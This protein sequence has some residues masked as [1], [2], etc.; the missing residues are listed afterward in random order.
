MFS[1]KLENLIKAALQ[2]GVLTE[3]EKNAIIKRAQAEG[4]DIDEVDI[5][6]QSLQ[7]KRQAELQEKAQ[8]TADE[9]LKARK[10]A[11]EAKTKADQEEEKERATILR[12]CPKCGTLI[13]NLTNVCPECGFIIDK[14]ETDKDVT[15]IIKLL[16]ECIDLVD[17]NDHDCYF[18]IP[19]F[20][21]KNYKN[22][23]KEEY[24]KS[25]NLYDFK[26]NINN[27]TI[28]VVNNYRGIITEASLYKDND[29]IHSLLNELRLKEKTILLND[30]N[31]YIK[32][33]KKLFNPSD[34][35]YADERLYDMWLEGLEKRF[36]Y[37]EDNYSDLC[38]D[39]IVRI[40]KNIQEIEKKHEELLSNSK[41]IKAVKIQSGD[42]TPIHERI[43]EK[44]RDFL[45]WIS[46]KI[47]SFE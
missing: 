21:E 24:E 43:F 14:T 35:D 47:K 6:I 36:H 42:Y 11:Q 1:E 31:K 7:Q 45:S 19:D 32:F 15:K 20:W 33:T 16:Q 17:L 23:P 8:K 29:I 25:P 34:K 28:R 22:I 12:K 5:Y 46:D 4:E 30:T 27:N 13:P 9:E 10:K 2:D 37:L 26:K 39:D 38:K 44:G 41:Y 3:Q 18:H 40:E